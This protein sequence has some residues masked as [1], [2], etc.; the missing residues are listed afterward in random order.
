MASS[1]FS[2]PQEL[3]P[4]VDRS[5]AA[6]AVSRRIYI[7]PSN[8][9]QFGQNGDLQFRLPTA[10]PGSILDAKYTYMKFTVEVEFDTPV[11]AAVANEAVYRWPASGGNSVFERLEVYQGGTPI[12]QIS[13]YN[14][15]AKKYFQQEAGSIGLPAWYPKFFRA[16]INNPDRSQQTV[17]TTEY[18]Q[19]T[20]AHHTFSIDTFDTSQPLISL[21]TRGPKVPLLR[22]ILQ[23]LGWILGILCKTSELRPT[24]FT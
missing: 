7:P 5:P 21:T 17:P 12:E 15:I 18:E 3:N 10:E 9:T 22:I 13:H 8:G 24:R 11:G 16:N 4:G 2:V 19:S 1:D 14:I 23:L 20:G 6:P